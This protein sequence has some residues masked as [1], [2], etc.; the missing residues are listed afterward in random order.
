MSSKNSDSFYLV[1][2]SPH[3]SLSLILML[4]C[5]KHV[6]TGMTHLALESVG[7]W[8]RSWGYWGEA[9]AGTAIQPVNLDTNACNDLHIQWFKKP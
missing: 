3:I 9:D 6:T 5:T 2:C 7:W 1:I 4:S 8:W